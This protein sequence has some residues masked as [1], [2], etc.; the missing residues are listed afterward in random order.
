MTETSDPRL[1][2]AG[3]DVA[4]DADVHP[5]GLVPPSG[6]KHA[7]YR[8]SSSRLGGGAFGEVLAGRRL[9]TGEPVALK[10]VVVRAPDEGIPDNLLREL[11]TL[12]HLSGRSPHVVRLLDHYPLGNAVVLVL[13]LCPRGDL[14]SL[15]G[16]GAAGADP[17]EG[18]DPRAHLPLTPACVK[19]VVRQVFM[20]LA[21]CHSL[22]VIHR[23]VKPG[24]VLVGAD[25]RLKLADFGLARFAP[26]MS[27]RTSSPRT[28]PGT[29]SSSPSP[30]VLFGTYTPAIQTRWYRAPEIL[31]GARDYSAAVD[32]WSAG[33]ILAELLTPNGPILPGDSDIDQLARTLTLLGTPDDARWPDA[34]G[35]PDYE[36]I[37]FAPRLPTSA[38]DALPG[39]V[40]PGLATD[41]LFRALALDPKTRPTAEEAL[42]DEYFHAAPAAAS[43][44]AALEELRRCALRGDGDTERSRGGRGEGGGTRAEVAE[45]DF[46]DALVALGLDGELEGSRRD[47]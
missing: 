31:Y 46:R 6:P 47:G 2:D 43:P 44:E 34:R 17:R 45:D 22:G 19:G 32:V 23:D 7:Q 5:P 30:G 36:K 11:K 12:Q 21:A 37:A 42:R 8:R 1:F 16:V 39:N 3:E 15:L 20:G 14:R 26:G 13:E 4:W 29:I 9:A 38:R 40:D 25:A 18:R 24:N 35:L 10:R 33:A 28:S 27:P 41:F